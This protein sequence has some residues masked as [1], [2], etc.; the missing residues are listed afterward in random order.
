MI[1]TYSINYGG[2][3]GTD[4][5]YQIEVPDDATEADIDALVSEDYRMKLEEN[6]YYE[7]IDVEEV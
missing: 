7:I 6:C 2:Y 5:E 1:V 3:I 4:A